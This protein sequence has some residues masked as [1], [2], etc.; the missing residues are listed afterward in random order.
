MV[1][2]LTGQL[3]GTNIPQT[4]AGHEQPWTGMYKS[5]PV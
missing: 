5:T 4:K 3:A 1:N 2:T